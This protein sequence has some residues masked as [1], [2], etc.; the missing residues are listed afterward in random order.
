MFFLLVVLCMCVCLC[1]FVC[2]FFSGSGGL[3]GWLLSNLLLVGKEILDCFEGD[4]RILFFS[5]N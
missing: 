5:F 2:V 4:L 1:F 3:G